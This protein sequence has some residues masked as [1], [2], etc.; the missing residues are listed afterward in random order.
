MSKV[1]DQSCQTW[2]HFEPYAL[3]KQWTPDNAVRWRLPKESPGHKAHDLV[4]LNVRLD[5][6]RARAWAGY[7]IGGASLF[8]FEERS[9]QK[10]FEE[11]SDVGL[12]RRL[13]QYAVRVR[14]AL[15][16][17]DVIEITVPWRQSPGLVFRWSLEGAPEAIAQACLAA[18]F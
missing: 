6:G 4:S 16:E 7:V 14:N 12:T 11:I 13:K 2:V 15:R 3:L 17:S 10:V 5:D 8:L 9:M 18:E 1:G